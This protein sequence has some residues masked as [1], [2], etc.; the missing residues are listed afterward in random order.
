MNALPRP[1]VGLLSL[2]LT[3]CGGSVAG[4]AADACGAGPLFSVLPVALVDIDAIS[5]FGGL[6]APGHTLPTAHAGIYLDRVGAQVSSPGDLRVTGVR[7]TR[8]RTSPNRQGVEDYS[9]DFSLCREVTGWFGHLS[10]LSPDLRPSESAW[11]NCSTYNT[12]D[13][14]VEVC[15]AS[16]DRARLPAGQPIGTSGH[17]R[18]L[19]LMS[20]DFGLLDSRVDNRYVARWRH[21]EPSHRAVCPWDRFAPEARAQLYSK[22]ADRS[23]LG[24]QPAGEP[25]CGTMQV[26]VASTAKGVWAETSV[27]TPAA[28]DET[29]YITLADYP[30]RPVDHLALS[31][32]PAALGARVA[33]VPKATS[34]RVNRA[35][36]QIQPDGTVH[37]YGP[38]AL[39][40]TSSWLIALTGPSALTIR[41]VTHPAGASPCLA[42][43]ATWSTAGGVAMVR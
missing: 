18:E 13:E 4:P 43:P 28:G 21:P 29:R 26:D 32:G 42:D 17:S 1:L 40:P 35:F 33:V 12:S 37:C 41:R 15:T 30:Y 22:L 27:N 16:L 6:G 9:I 34:G 11:R 39:F 31:L 20:L 5:V 14:T 38:D 8:Y 24:V 23:R 19:G 7:R 36:E 25:R 3:A 2:L 10:S